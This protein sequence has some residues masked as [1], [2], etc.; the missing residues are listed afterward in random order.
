MRISSLVFISFSFILLLFAATTY[1]NF[2][3]SERVKENSDYVTLSSSIVQNGNR[4]QRNILNMTSGLRGFLLT[5]ENY[6][7]ETYDS[8]AHENLKIIHELS[9]Q[10]SD[11]SRQYHL[12]KDI[13]KLNTQWI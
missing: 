9:I 2:R 10:I 12:L 1:I 11:T 8:A 5:G 4:F 13:E 3:Q 7:L 6:F